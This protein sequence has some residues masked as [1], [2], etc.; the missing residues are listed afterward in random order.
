MAT[1]VSAVVGLGNPGSEYAQTRHNVGFWFID[2]L[3]RQQGAAL[4]ADRKLHGEAGSIRLEAQELRLLKP[5]TFVNRS[6]QAVAALASYYKLSP[7]EILVI[8]DDLDLEPGVIRLK[9]NGG[10]G[11]H[12][13]LKDIIAHLGGD[14]PRLRI[15]IGHP[16]H[17][18]RVVDFVLGR[19][20]A[21]E[22]GLI[23]QAINQGLDTLPMILT[24]GLAK[25][26]QHLH[27]DKPGP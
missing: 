25:A 10:H 23:L 19:P 24:Q 6:G 3:S 16:G 5:A 11:G 7:A 27:T 22:E 17:R 26:T 13:G 21:D 1:A 9:A 15:G 14:F 8:H 2:L 4:R 12:N 20:S 18:D